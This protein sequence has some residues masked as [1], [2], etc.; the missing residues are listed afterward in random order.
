MSEQADMPREHTLPIANIVAT[1]QPITL[2]RPASRCPH[3]AHKIKWYE[4]IPLV[5]GYYYVDAVQ[6]AKHL[7][8]CVILSLS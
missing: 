2:S 7:L 6:A 4:N 8:V 5:A 1:D 3:C